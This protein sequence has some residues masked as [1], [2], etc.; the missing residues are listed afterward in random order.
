MDTPGSYMERVNGF[1]GNP[2]RERN[3]KELRKIAL[4]FCVALQSRLGISRSVKTFFSHFT[5]KNDRL[6]VLKEF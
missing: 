2:R 4:S 1:W 3:A 6:L 5:V